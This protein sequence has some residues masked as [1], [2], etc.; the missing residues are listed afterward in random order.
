MSDAPERI[1]AKP[2]YDS[3]NV[4]GDWYED[5]TGGGIEYTR[6]DLSPQSP[7]GSPLF[8]RGV[9]I[10]VGKRQTTAKMAN[11]YQIVRRQYRP[12]R[13]GSSSCRWFVSFYGRELSYHMLE[14]TADAAAQAHHD[15]AILSALE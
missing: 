4:Y 10:Y 8:W 5:S 2:G 14:K 3:W 15:S 6:A 7:K 11:G 9:A 1:W 12:R 13:D